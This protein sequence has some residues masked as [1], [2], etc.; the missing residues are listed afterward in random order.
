MKFLIDNWMLISVA[1]ASGGMLLWPV[2]QGAASTGLSAAA[3]VQLINREKAVVVDVSEKE[4]FAAGHVGGAK[5]VPVGELEQ[6]L[7]EVVKNKALPVILVCPSGSRANR[8]LGVAKKLGYEQ[9]QVL[10]GGLKSW[11]EA[12]LPIEKA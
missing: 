9:A 12:N 8:A 5:N 3:A 10:A 2:I 11:K 4:E 7:P 1:L 6:R